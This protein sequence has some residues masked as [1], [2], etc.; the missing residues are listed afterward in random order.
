LIASHIYSQPGNFTI[1]LIVTDS[2]TN[3]GAL[4]NTKSETV[5]V[6]PANIQTTS[7]LPFSDVG[8]LILLGIVALVL[9]VGAA[10]YL[11]LQKAR[12][13]AIR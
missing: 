2:G 13:P 9:L 4:S 3:P 11:V 12:R 7:R 5:T 1:T 10:V 8:R 6:K